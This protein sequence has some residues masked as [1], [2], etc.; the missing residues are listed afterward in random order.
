MYIVKNRDLSDSWYCYHSNIGNDSYVVL[1]G[2]GGAVVS[3][4]WG[5]TSPSSSVFT[6]RNAALN[7]S[8][9]NRLIAYCFADV[10]GYSKIGNYL[11]SGSTDGTFVYTGFRPRFV[12]IKRSSATEDWVIFDTAR[13]TFNVTNLIL[14]PNLSNSEAAAASN[15]LDTLSNGF[16]LR[17]SG[18]A[19][20]ASGGTYIYMAFA[21]APFAL[22]NRAR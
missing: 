6:L 22:N 19:V 5:N 14:Y 10:P 12:M 20:N 11:G 13:N 15:I 17:N 8:T 4:V 1:N 18:A 16:K 2:S 7:L 21:E 3:N 9:T